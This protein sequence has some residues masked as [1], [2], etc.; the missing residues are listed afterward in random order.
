M[1][2]AQSTTNTNSRMYGQPS[3]SILHNDID[4]ESILK[5]VETFRHEEQKT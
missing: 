5:D 4:E 2:G 3:K 1:M